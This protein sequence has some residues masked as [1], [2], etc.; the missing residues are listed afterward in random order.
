MEE[1]ANAT[2]FVVL[3]EGMGT[4]KN[5]FNEA[6]LRAKVARETKSAHATTIFN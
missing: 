4:S 5:G 1:L 6:G 2:H 3:R